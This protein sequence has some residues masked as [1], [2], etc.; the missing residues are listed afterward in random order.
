MIYGEQDRF[1]NIIDPKKEASQDEDYDLE[2]SNV[3]GL[4][5]INIQYDNDPCSMILFR[6]W[7]HNF[8]Y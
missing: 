7:T 5:V 3:V 6:N 4:N 1:Y 2:N 8:K